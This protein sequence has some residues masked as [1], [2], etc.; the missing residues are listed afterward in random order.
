V[1]DCHQQVVK[2]TRASADAGKPW[3]VAFDEPGDATF[4]MP[5]DD[6]YPGMAKL[7][8]GKEAG[9]IPTVDDI[10]KYTLWGTLL[11]GGQ[12]VEYYF[13]YR[14]PQN[15]LLCEDWRSR[16]QSWDYAR[17]ALDFFQDNKIPF[18]DMKSSDELVGG[19]DREGPVYCF[20][21]SPEIHLVYLTGGGG[22]EIALPGKSAFRIAW[23]NPRTGEL[24]KPRKLDSN[25]LRAPDKNDWLAVIRR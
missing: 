6:D 19:K 11:A 16:D 1:R 4:G 14:L 10:R 8:S 23:F 18:H 12:G 5:P 13:G 22:C 15:D 21:K 9:K 20:A 17:I 24:G 7:R 3:V 2:W 25:R